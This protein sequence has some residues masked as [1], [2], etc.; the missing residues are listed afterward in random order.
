MTLAE[1]LAQPWPNHVLAMR[2]A[3]GNYGFYIAMEKDG[4]Y[5][6]VFG[7]SSGKTSTLKEAANAVAEIIK[8]KK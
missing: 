3:M 5:W 4:Y 8:V 7:H 6:Y 2:Y 1:E